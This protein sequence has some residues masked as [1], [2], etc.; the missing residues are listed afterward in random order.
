MSRMKLSWPGQRGAVMLFTF[1]VMTTLTAVTVT[2]LSMSAIQIKAKG[3][4]IASSKALWLAE[5]GL[6]KAAWNL[7]T[8][9]A[10]G[11]QGEDWVSPGTTENL[12]N[13]S[14]T[15]AVAR[16]DFA[17]AVNG[18][19][20]AATSEQGA[21][22][23]AN[24]IDASDA[25]YWESVNQPTP[26]NPE[27]IIITF[28]YTLILNKAR[29]LIPATTNRVPRNY[30]WQVSTDGI[31]YTTVVNVVNN[32]NPDV[33]DS[34]SAVSNVNYLKLKVT[35]VGIVT[36]PRGGPGVPR[37]FIATLEALG[38]K[39]TLTA[40]VNGLNRKIEQT[41]VADDATQTAFDQIDWNEIFPAS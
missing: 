34:F 6:Q 18:S 39:I 11:G 14:Y 33:T 19:S 37:V 15:M 27:E 2:F 23:A 40:S 41:V 1:I 36:P 26:A 5:A 20:A 7:K 13:G 35:S 30:S 22:V 16:W 21:N 12:G 32:E 8:P 17:L 4:D 25:T 3:D 9:V 31:T 24:A 38:S 28:P 10:S 29:F